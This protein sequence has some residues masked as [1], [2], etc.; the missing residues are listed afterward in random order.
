MLLLEFLTASACPWY[1]SRRGMA[2][3]QSGAYTLPS[4][5][6][7][8]GAGGITHAEYQSYTREMQCSPLH[9]IVDVS[10]LHY[11]HVR[12]EGVMVRS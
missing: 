8:R 11:A 4:S 5:L 10:A 3:D 7:L 12:L 2:C 1:V 6:L 9:P